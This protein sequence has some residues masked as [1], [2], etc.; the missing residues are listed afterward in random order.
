MS[1]LVAA[2]LSPLAKVLARAAVKLAV[3]LHN[4]PAHELAEKWRKEI[5]E[6]S[7]QA[8]KIAV[9]ILLCAAA[10][11]CLA[12]KRVFVYA[13]DSID[14]VLTEEQTAQ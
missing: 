12:V 1:P 9:I 13:H 10:C 8:A 3:K 14:E 5:E 6:A 2:A 11:G 4:G 7:K